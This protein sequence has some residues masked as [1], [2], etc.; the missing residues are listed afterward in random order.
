ML[1]GGLHRLHGGRDRACGHLRAV[2]CDQLVGTGQP[3]ERDGRHPVLRLGVVGADVLAD[4]LRVCSWRARGR[5]RAAAASTPARASGGAASRKPLAPLSLLLSR[6]RRRRGLNLHHIDFPGTI[7][8]EP[9]V[10]IAFCLNITKSVAYH[11]FEKILIVNGHG[12]N[13]PLIDLVARKTVLETQSLC[14]ATTYFWFLMEAFEKVRESKVIAHADEFETSLY[15]HLAARPGADGQGRRGQRP[16]G[17]VRQQRQHGELLRPLQRLLGPLDEDRRPRRPHEGAPP[18]RAGS[19]ST[20]PW[21][22]IVSLVD[23]LRAWP[24]ERRADMHAGP[25]QSAN[26]LVTQTR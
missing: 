26:S 6:P 23:E 5:R 12:S 7:H 9:D 10:F 15:L 17:Q 21:S 14:F 11:G 25:V 20:R 3:Q 2:A 13:A 18:R 24:I 1:G 16:D 19:S 8:I 22:G 4:H